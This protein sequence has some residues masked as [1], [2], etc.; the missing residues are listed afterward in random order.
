MALSVGTGGGP[1]CG[2]GAVEAPEECDDNNTTAGDG[3]SASCAVEPGFACHG[4]P[5]RCSI[6][7]GDGVTGPGETCDDGGNAGGDGCSVYCH[8]EAGWACTGT[9]S[10]CKEL[11]PGS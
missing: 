7:C 11:T 8:L 1:V 6:V 2:N 5:S 9:P 3:C 10:A 4:V